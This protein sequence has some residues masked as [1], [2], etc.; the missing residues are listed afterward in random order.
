M[1][2]LIPTRTKMAFATA[3]V[4]NIKR[5]GLLSM[6]CPLQQPSTIVGSSSLSS[7]SFSPQVS[8]RNMSSSAVSPTG[9]Q[10][11]R[12]GRQ[13]HDSS[14]RSNVN[15]A[16]AVRRTFSSSSSSTSTNNN[17]NNNPLSRYGL[18]GHH[19]RQFD[20]NGYKNLISE[21]LT[22]RVN[23]FEIAGQDGGDI[24]MVGAIQNIME[25]SP[26]L[27]LQS[28][29]PITLTTRI[30][31][32]TLTANSEEEGEASASPVLL[33]GDVIL[34]EEEEDDDTSTASKKKDQV[35]HNLSKD[36]ILNTVEQSPLLEL[37]QEP[38]FRS[39]L[40]VV[41]LIHNPEVQ[42]LDL[43]KLHPN[44]SNDDRQAFIDQSWQPALQTLQEYSS[45]SQT[46]SDISFGIVSNGLGIPQELDHP[47]HL[48][49]ETVMGAAKTNSKFS[50]VELPANLLERHGIHLSKRLHEELVVTGDNPNLD[51][52]GMRPLTCYPDLGTGNSHP[53][54]LVDYELPSTSTDPT[55]K[56]TTQYTHEM[57]S[58]PALYHIALQTTTSHFDAEE[59]LEAKQTRDLT[60]EERE[61]LDGCK[62][63]QSMIHDLDQ[64]LDHI[65][66]FAAHEEE[67]YGR[68]I[69][70]LYDTFEAIDDSTSDVLQAYFAA[71]ALAVRYAIA[72][73]TRQILKKGEKS[74][75]KKDKTNKN[76]NHI[77]SKTQLYPDIPDQM[78]LQ[79]YA[80]RY[81]LSKDK[82][83]FTR[84]VIGASTLEDFRR[85]INLMQTLITDD[86]AFEDAVEAATNTG[87]RKNEKDS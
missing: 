84:L 66:S 43:L 38:E 26:D 78:T 6:S 22:R 74:G 13:K 73:K 59:I 32:R 45:A 15:I 12:G 36:Y 1:I 10:R 20:P 4:P 7:Q 37:L 23:Y 87:E 52:V 85:Q 68:I 67:L 80:L 53:F 57:T 40:R 77:S 27:L 49:V 63:V 2:R 46:N 76:D 75:D 31:Y 35:V 86:V 47:M 79:E 24:A 62:L 29:E 72:K 70:L 5:G 28:S 14:C 71:Y 58:I 17:D 9:V 44:A 83:Y 42:V 61:T 81:L 48:S 55:T 11:G 25:N 82:A 16:T 19:W 39:R 21:A 54:R 56:K 18:G 64:D 34:T 50:T 8:S 41:Y 30:G 51:I 65:R 69:P 60:M 33:P 3:T